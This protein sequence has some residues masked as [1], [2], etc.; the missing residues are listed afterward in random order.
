[1]SKENSETVK[2]YDDFAAKKYVQ[3]TIEHIAADPEKAKNKRETLK[4]FI[5]EGFSTL[6]GKAKIFEI[7]SGDGEDAVMIKNLG[8]DI[9]P[10]DVADDFIDTIKSKGLN[11]IKFNIIEDNFTEKYNGIYYWR[12]FVHFTEKDAEIALSKIYGALEQG[13]R[14]IFNMMNNVEKG[15]LDEE[16][17]DFSGEYHLGAKRYYKYWNADIAKNLIEKTGFKIIKFEVETKK[18]R[19]INVIAEKTA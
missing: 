11:P 6:P 10:S 5:I 14:A 18:N 12:T 17:V 7:G 13:G 16:W 9:T 15:G 1:M 3:S 2:I 8:F 19:W 4:N